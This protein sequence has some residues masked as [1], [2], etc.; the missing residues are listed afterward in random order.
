MLASI[1]PLGERGR[2]QHY[3]VTVATFI[4]SATFAGAFLGGGARTR[5]RARS[6]TND[7]RSS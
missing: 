7:R 3:P 2:N 4:A 1:N 6:R 5:R